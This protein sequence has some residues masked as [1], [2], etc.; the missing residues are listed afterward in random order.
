MNNIK[1]AALLPMKGHSERVKNKNLK[2]FNGMPLMCCILKTLTAC[3]AVSEIYINTDSS[4]ISDTALRY[5]PDVKII[6]RP[7]EL[8][9]DFV[10]MNDI[11]KYDMSVIDNEH[12]IQTHATNPLL[13]SKT[14]SAACDMYINNINE[15]D[16][17]FSV[18]KR[19]TRLYDKNTKAVNHNPKELIRTQDLEPLYEENSNIYIFSRKSF[20]ASGARIGENPKLFE[21][22]SIE[23]VD[24]DNEIDFI[25]AEYLFKLREEGRL[26][27]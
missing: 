24:I 18:T 25:F 2:S 4:E 23:A 13:T 16:S 3:A 27:I 10:S 11:I 22:N 19:Q 1:F 7:A 6:E 9:G 20:S 8:C 17:I 5:F 21:M 12:F 14:L 15:Y 26:E